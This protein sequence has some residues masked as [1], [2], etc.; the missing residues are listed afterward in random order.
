MWLLEQNGTTLRGVVQAYS[1]DTVTVFVDGYADPYEYNTKY[2]F[3]RFE[4]AL[5]QSQRHED[6]ESD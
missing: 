6:F 2:V 5:K 1:N 4:D 3:K